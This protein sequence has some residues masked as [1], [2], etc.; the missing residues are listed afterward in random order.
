MANGKPYS[1]LGEVLDDLA[2]ARNVRGPYPIER[3]LKEKVGKSPSGQAISDYLY[4]EYNPRPEFIDL[5]ATA[6]ELT[7]KERGMLAWVYAYRFQPAA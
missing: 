6:F 5:F 3:Y 4:G 7:P 2:R 1:E